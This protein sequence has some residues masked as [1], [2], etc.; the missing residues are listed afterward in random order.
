ME[1][2][3]TGLRIKVD[4]ERPVAAERE[5]L[6]QV[7]RGGRLARTALEVDDRDNLQVV[8]P[9]PS[10]QVAPVRLPT[11]VE[12]SP[13]SMDV[14]DR[15]RTTP[16]GRHVRLRSPPLERQPSQVTRVDPNQARDLSGR[17]A[18][19]GLPGGGREEL[20]PVLLQLLGKLARVTADEFMD[21]RSSGCLE[22]GDGG[23]VQI[24]CIRFGLFQAAKSVSTS[25]DS[26]N[27]ARTKGLT[28]VNHCHGWS[29]GR[30]DEA[31]SIMAPPAAVQ[32]RRRSPDV[33]PRGPATSASICHDT[34]I[35]TIAGRQRQLKCA[36]VRERQNNC[37]A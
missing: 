6:G 23:H 28:A 20:E 18:A 5:V 4:R 30:P 3:Q 11:L 9:A 26:R 13:K 27:S 37:I 14:V 15:V 1:G 12:K 32:I 19:Q 10:R 34:I 36:L 24:S 17:E 29:A 16:I 35:S 22:L 21:G 25:P 7:G 31:Y 2:R 8:G 33:P